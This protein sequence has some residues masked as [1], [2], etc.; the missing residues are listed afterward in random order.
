MSVD[1]TSFKIVVAEKVK[2][3]VVVL[4][5]GHATYSCFDCAAMHAHAEEVIFLAKGP[6]MG[7][8]Y[9]THP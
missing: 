4:G 2:I 3:T 9:I 8:V 1:F 7:R 5:E 6:N